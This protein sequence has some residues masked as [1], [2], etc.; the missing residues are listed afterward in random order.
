MVPYITK[1]SDFMVFEEQDEK[2]SML[3]EDIWWEKSMKECRL[4]S[5][6]RSLRHS[7]AW[8]LGGSVA[9]ADETSSFSKANHSL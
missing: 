2:D 4:I 7:I 8:R 9:L 6:R 3:M 5:R 1:L